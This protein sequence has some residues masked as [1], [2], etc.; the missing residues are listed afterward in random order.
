[1][2]THAEFNQPIE[3]WDVKNVRNMSWMFS[4][5]KFNQDISSWKTGRFANLVNMFFD[6]PIK[7]VY[8]VK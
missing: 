4:E 1:M 3:D 7:E 8:K 5:S 6:C 2:F